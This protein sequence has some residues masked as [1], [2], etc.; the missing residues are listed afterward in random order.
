MVSPTHIY[1]FVNLRAKNDVEVIEYY[2]VPSSVVAKKTR[3]GKAKTTG[4]EWYS[5]YLE[6]ALKYKDDWSI[7]QNA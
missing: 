6:D 5:F 7:F 3:Y 4:S 2:I 1:A